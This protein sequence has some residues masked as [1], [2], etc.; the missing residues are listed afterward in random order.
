MLSALKQL[1]PCCLLAGL[2][3]TGCEE[4]KPEEKKPTTFCLSDTIKRTTTID[5]A[6]ISS[7]DD[8]LHL[9]GE[10]SFDE[11]KIVKVFPNSTGQVSEVK[12]TLGDRVQ[13][14]QVLAVI[15][16][17]DVAGNYN[18]LSS[19]EADVKIA[20]RQMDNAASLFKSGLASQKEFEEAKLQYDKAVA[21]R[22]KIQS[23]I[24]IN[25]GGNMQAGGQY[26][27]KSPING[28][29]VEKKVNAGGFIRQDMNDNLFTISDLK[30]VWV[31]ANVYEA[32]ISKVKEGY[33]AVVTTLAYPDKKFSGKIDK[34]SNVLDP[35]NK[36]LRIRIRLQ[37]AD[38]L[39]KP[40]MFT[41]VT[42]SNV[43]DQQ[44][45]CI[46]LTALVEENSETYV[47]LYNNDCDLKVA[48]VDIMKKTG[49]KAFLKSGVSAGQKLLTHNA[50]LVYDEFTDNQK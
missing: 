25:G 12:V 32:D 16:S 17:A 30:D 29:I 34:V 3:S 9:S 38:L 18:D 42:I 26:I 46:P 48:R 49:D 11:N 4:K 39:L 45:V 37:N 22:N 6:R 21:S 23:L 33:S 36:V 2:L 13:A 24:T 31:W 14:G 8:E 50:L 7:I 1:V 20:Q 41:N 28:Y 15:K 40:E 43:Q 44:A 35:G 5:T 10:V 27:I 19:A 47:I